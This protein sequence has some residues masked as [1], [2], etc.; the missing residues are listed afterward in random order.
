LCFINIIVFGPCL[1]H[2][3]VNL[4]IELATADENRRQQKLHQQQQQEHQQDKRRKLADRDLNAGYD[5]GTRQREA[6]LKKKIEEANRNIAPESTEEPSES[7]FSGLSVACFP[8]GDEAAAIAAAAQRS[9]EEHR[10]SHQ[11]QARKG[12]RCWVP[13]SRLVQ[14]GAELH[15]PYLQRPYPLTDDVIAE[16]YDML[17]RHYEPSRTSKHGLH[18]RLELSYRLQKPKLLSDMNAFKAANPGAIFQD[19]INWYGNPG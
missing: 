7:E 3:V 11:Q 4:C 18:R 1:L 13:G 5:T 15:A 10:Q 12:A 6:D 2:Q 19:F 14:T 17:T 16:R 8:G 9:M